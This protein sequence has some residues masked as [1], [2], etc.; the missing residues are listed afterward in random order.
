MIRRMDWRLLFFISFILL[1]GSFVFSLING[2]SLVD[3]E[4]VKDALFHYNG[5]DQQQAI[6]RDVRLPRTLAAMVIG[7]CLAVAG[8]L[9]QGMTRNLL[10]DSG[11]LGINAGAAFS[12]ALV[13]A[14]FSKKTYLLI[15]GFAFFGAAL[16][17][18]LIFLVLHFSKGGMSPIRVVLAGTAINSLLVSLSQ[19]IA[20]Y[21]NLSQDLAYWFF[22]GTAN[23]SWNQLRIILPFFAISILG[24]I[25]ISGDITLLSFGDETAIGLGKNPNRIRSFTM[26]IVLFLAGTAVSLVGSVSFVGLMVP[27]F[28]R[29]IAGQDYRWIVPFS[30]IF[31]AVFVTIADVLARLVNPPF[32]TSFGIL[33]SL[34]GVP[35]LLYLVWREES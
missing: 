28:V 8:A 16:A 29:K 11:L 19:C 22:G 27:H 32:E 18:G 23:V 4:V 34:I 17:T 1:A 35:F 3:V 10:A 21:F 12:T 9:M 26:V 13:F 5:A 31:G 25:L 24:S 15:S 30:G 20:L 33:I 2:A 14:F 7:C 6:I